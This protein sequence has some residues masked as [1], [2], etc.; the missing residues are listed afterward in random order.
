MGALLAVLACSGFGSGTEVSKPEA[1]RQDAGDSGAADTAPPPMG[2]LWF[3]ND[4]LEHLDGMRWTTAEVW[5]YDGAGLAPAASKDYEMEPAVGN[6]MWT[7]SESG[8]CWGVNQL[9]IAA[10][11]YL[12]FIITELPGVEY[13]D[14]YGLPACSAGG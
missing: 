6:V 13:T 9:V 14:T 5:S 1:G 4:T 12:E 10:G 8:T 11:D 7:G 2:T 3:R